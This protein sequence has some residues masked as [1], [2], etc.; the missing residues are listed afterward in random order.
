MGRRRVLESMRFLLGALAVWTAGA[1]PL[2]LGLKA[3]ATLTGDIDSYEAVSESKRITFG[4][5]AVVALPLGF[6]V[7]VDALYQRS[8]Y[9]VQDS[10]FSLA[11]SY[12]RARGNSFEFPVL[13]RRNLGRG[14]F[15]AGGYA[16]R[17]VD[18][19][20]D[21]TLVQAVGL[22]GQSYETFRFHNPGEWQTTQGVVAAAGIEERL[23][24]LR[25]GPEVRYTHW[26]V[27]ALDLQGSH[28][29]SVQSPRNR[30]EV[31]LDLRFP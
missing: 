26:K 28:G 11:W 1:Q 30:V 14:I 6:G 2:S 10:F 22:N 21:T 13:L 7:E 31:F 17:V 16:A 27:P 5:A 24:P 8:G 12:T 19:S 18:G 15:V 9:R 4:A 25:L 23:G 20:E 3:G 29:F